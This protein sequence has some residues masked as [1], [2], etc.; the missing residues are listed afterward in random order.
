MLPPPLTPGPSGRRRIRIPLWAFLVSILVISAALYFIP[1]LLHRHPN[2]SLRDGRRQ[3]P[4]SRYMQTLPDGTQICLNDSSELS[5]QGNFKAPDRRDLNIEG[6]AYL[7]VSKDPRP[8]TIH[9]RFFDVKTNGGTLDIDAYKDDTI[10][11]TN[12]FGDTATITLLRD[13]SKKFGLRSG[14]KLIVQSGSEGSGRSQPVVTLDS[15][16]YLPQDSLYTES[17]WVKYRLAVNNT[18]LEELAPRLQRIYH[19]KF[20]I[21]GDQLKNQRFSLVIPTN[22]IYFTLTLLQAIQPFRYT[23]DR[24]EVHIQPS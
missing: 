21:T 4:Q 22:D 18:T 3:H 6:E 8:F 19:I 11:E 13:P 7:I 10:N 20:S 15:L 23:I 2:V 9:T 1:H 5:Y 24:R 17:A 14:Q 12:V 16:H